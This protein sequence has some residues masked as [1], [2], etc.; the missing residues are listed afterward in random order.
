MQNHNMALIRFTKRSHH[1]TEDSGGSITHE[2]SPI[3]AMKTERQFGMKT[4][5]VVTT[6]C[7]MIIMQCVYVAWSEVAGYT[8]QMEEPLIL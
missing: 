8:W 3:T 2:S 4:S 5:S 1:L 7:L 6:I